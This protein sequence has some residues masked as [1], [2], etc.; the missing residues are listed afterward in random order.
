MLGQYIPK[1][2]QPLNRHYQQNKH[3]QFHLLLRASKPNK[4]I[5]NTS[6]NKHPTLPKALDLFFQ[7]V[8]QFPVL[9]SLPITPPRIHRA[10]RPCNQFL[11][12]YLTESVQVH[13]DQSH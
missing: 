2:E 11:V 6:H 8:T 10:L 4:N 5:Q 3:F 7:V 13:S 9:Q 12:K 1:Q